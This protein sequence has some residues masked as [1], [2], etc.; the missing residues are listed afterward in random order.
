MF[1]DVPGVLFV[2]DGVSPDLIRAGEP[3]LRNHRD[4]D[5]AE[6]REPV[7]RPSLLRKLARPVTS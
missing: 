6:V 4:Q 5:A 2:Q 1:R 3:R 7:R